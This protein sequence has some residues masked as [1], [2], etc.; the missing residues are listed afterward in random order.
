MPAS[1]K[2]LLWSAR[3]CQAL[4]HHVSADPLGPLCPN[5]LYPRTPPLG[6]ICSSAMI[7]I[8]LAPFV[9]TF[10]EALDSIGSNVYC[11]SKLCI[12]AIAGNTV[13]EETR[14]KGLCISC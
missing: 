12:T 1:F 4:E 13:Q 14:L 7:P 3:L 6:A 2:R 5:L 11:A 8:Q 9:P 10:S